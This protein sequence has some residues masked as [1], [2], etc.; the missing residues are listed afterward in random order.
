MVYIALKAIG[1]VPK[2]SKVVHCLANKDEKVFDG[3]LECKSKWYFQV[4]WRMQNVVRLASTIPSQQLVKFYQLLLAGIAVEPN[5]SDKEYGAIANAN[6][7]T[8]GKALLAITDDVEPPDPVAPLPYDDDEGIMVAGPPAPKPKP[9][10][11]AGYPGPRRPAKAG[12]QVGLAPLPPGGPDNAGAGGHGDGRP[13]DHPP[14]LPP[15]PGP[16]PVLPEPPPVE[17]DDDDAIMGAVPAP[18]P[19]LHPVGWTDTEGWTTSVGGARVKYEVYHP[20]GKDPYPNWWLQCPT[21]GPR[22]WKT[23]KDCAAHTAKHGKVECLAFL[24]CW[25]PMPVPAKPGATHR[26]ATPS[27]D[28]VRAF[29]EAHRAE[30]EVVCDKV[31]L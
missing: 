30:L 16:P 6:R 10:P 8:K 26:G 13:P 9:K 18:A 4:C 7:G 1:W 25:W 14:P 5:L 20:P 22:C 23:R 2:P 11:R 28:D 12:P 27:P 21:H 19:P 17:D 3:K 15:P 24:H 31:G 29:V